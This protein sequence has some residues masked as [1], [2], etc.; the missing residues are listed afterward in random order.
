MYY[1]HERHCSSSELRM[2]RPLAPKPC[3]GNDANQLLRRFGVDLIRDEVSYN[4]ALES[5]PAL[6]IADIY[7]QLT[8][9]NTNN[10][11][12]STSRVIAVCLRSFYSTRMLH[13]NIVHCIGVFQVA[14]SL[15]FVLRNALKLEKASSHGKLLWFWVNCMSFRCTCECP[16]SPHQL[17]TDLPLWTSESLL[18]LY[19]VHS[20]VKELKDY[21]RSGIFLYNW[22]ISTRLLLQQV[23]K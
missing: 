4:S 6:Y 14:I 7:S 8:S 9:S 17:T 12:D 3:V 15:E 18:H 10:K 21:P 20:A 1:L 5:C 16:T 22:R 23:G 19:T 13:S 2:R 11:D